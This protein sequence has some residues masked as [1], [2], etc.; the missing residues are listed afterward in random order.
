LGPIA[1]SLRGSWAVKK[2]SE[3]SPV[4][5][6]LRGVLKTKSSPKVKAK[7]QQSADPDNA[8]YQKYL[9]EKYL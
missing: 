4:T 9:E 7:R 1:A 6:S 3:L 8:A 2:P 5:N